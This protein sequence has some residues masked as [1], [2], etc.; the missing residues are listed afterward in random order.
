MNLNLKNFAVPFIFIFL[1]FTLNSQESLKS[2]E[3]DYYDFLSL[4]GVVKRPTLGYRSLS[5]NVWTF[6]EIESF[7]K[8]EEVTFTKVRTS[9]E[10]SPTHIWKNNN[11]GTTYTLWQP[12]SPIDNWFT[13]GIKQNF[14]V[15]IYGPEWF[16]SYN[17][18]TP[19]GQNDGALWQGRGYNTSLTA[20][21]RLEGYG[22]ELTVKPQVSFSQNKAFQLV[23]NSSFYTNEFG[24]IWG[25]GNDKGADAPQRFGDKAFWTYD[26]GDSEIRWS[27]YNLTL[28]F[29]TQSPWLGPAWLNPLLHSNNAA[30]YP[31]F[32]IGLRKTQIYIPY[33]NYYIGDIEFRFW[34]GK[35]S[36]SDYFDNDSSNDHNQITGMTLSYSPFFL[37]GLTL[38]INKIC[39]SKWDD[40]EFYKYFNP[41]YGTSGA[42]SGNEVED[43]K[44]SITLNWLVPKG[45]I[46]VYAEFGFDDHINAR[47]TINSY[48]TH[49]WHTFTYT[50]GLKKAFDIYK[51][52]N[53]SG[54]ILFEWNN[55]EMSQD[56]QMQYNYCFGFHHIIT[57][58]FTNK[59]QWLGSG[60]GYGGQS[61]YLG[62]K[63]YY[64]KG[65]SHIYIH[66][67]NPDN[68][69]LFK[70]AINDVS[71][72]ANGDLHNRTWNFYKGILTIG[73][74]S[75]YYITED[76]RLGAGLAYCH[77]VNPIYNQ[78]DEQ[79]LVWH[80]F[81]FSFSA[82]YNF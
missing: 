32:D 54:E 44:I 14:T 43:Q 48:T 22:F 50:F 70:E 72:G 63:I 36:E 28:G 61:Q 20:G 74:D 9:G 82:K 7:E 31:K 46:D 53:I 24:Y 64:P 23:D 5:D 56:F 33:I 57:Q 75:D 12:A 78:A 8:N 6:N 45:G 62:C 68:S 25:Y 10:Q 52:G 27:W 47:D 76:F 51:K 19:Y 79:Y 26:W 71:T 37:P 16:N 4:T 69:Y 17:T 21:L 59:G 40:N 67:Y 77:I 38:G 11:L 55:T 30:T 41:F 3:E 1:I 34:I 2:I 66:R 15:R 35:L 80:N 42:A 13:R 58:G 49:Y 73:V 65:L 81:R 60:I 39:I 29:G 18:A